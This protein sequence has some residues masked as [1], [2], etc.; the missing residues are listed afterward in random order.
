M[1]Q[2]IIF[3]D[4]IQAAF[5]VA[6]DNTQDDWWDLCDEHFDP[7]FHNGADGLLE[8]GFLLGQKAAKGEGPIFSVEAGTEGEWGF[9]VGREKSEII[10][11][12]EKIGVSDSP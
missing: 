2:E 1:N 11:A 9:F 6:V 12:L 4:K 5:D 7:D 8:I 10:S 3:D